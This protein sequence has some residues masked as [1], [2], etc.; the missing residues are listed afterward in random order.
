LLSCQG[1]QPAVF[2]TEIKPS[3]YPSELR[4]IGDHLKAKRLDLGL[5]QKDVASELNISPATLSRWELGISSPYDMHCGAIR[6]FLG[7]DPLSANKPSTVDEL[8]TDKRRELGWSLGKAA[9]Y[10]GVSRSAVTDW[11][12]G[13]TIHHVNHRRL[14]AKF[15]SIPELEMHNLMKK[16]W[17]DG[18]GKKNRVS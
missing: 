15:L 8:L 7:Y 6:K 4:T 17:N 18:H 3:G 1:I 12:K 5:F 14:V 16:R 2:I 10:F 13:K 11:E 9:K